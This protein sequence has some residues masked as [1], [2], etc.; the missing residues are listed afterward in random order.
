MPCSCSCL[1]MF[2]FICLDS[3]QSPRITVYRSIHCTHSLTIYSHSPLHPCIPAAN[4]H[5]PSV[6]TESFSYPGHR[7]G[8]PAAS[9]TLTHSNTSLPS[10]LLPLHSLIACIAPIILSLCH[11]AALSVIKLNFWVTFCVFWSP[12]VL[13]KVTVSINLVTEAA[14]RSEERFCKAHTVL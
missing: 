1:N 9:Q 12:V 14:V 13:W 4:P 11:S 7:K 8:S 3:R 5:Y 10:S 6:L 2:I